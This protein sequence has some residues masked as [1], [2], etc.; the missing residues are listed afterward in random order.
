MRLSHIAAPILALALSAGALPAQEA[1]DAVPDSRVV[2]ALDLDYPGSDIATLLDSSLDACQAACLN[3]SQCV[4][5]T[6]NQRSGSC[7][8]KFDIGAPVPF[9]GAISA[10]IVPTDPAVLM[11]EAQRTADLS[12]LE[13]WELVSASGLAQTIGRAHASNDVPASDLVAAA[14]AAGATIEGFRLLGAA[15]AVTDSPLLWLDY[16]R[17]G[18]TVVSPVSSE[19]STARSRVIPALANAYLRSGDPVLS[20][21]ILVEL[22]SVLQGQSRGPDSVAPLRLALDLAPSRATEELLDRAVGL[23]GF[24]VAE[25]QVDSDGA[26]PRLCVLFTEP[27]VQAGV[28]YAP[29]VQLPD[30]PFTTEVS[31]NQ[32]CLDGVEH[33]QR[34]RLVIR[35]GLPA[36]SGETTARAA[37]LTLY[38]RDRAPQVRFTTRAYVLPRT[39]EAALPVQ[40]VNLTDLDLTL[41]RLGDRNVLRAMDNGVF[42]QNLYEWDRD[43]I[44]GQMG[45]TVWEGSLT[46]GTDLNR[47]VT[48]RIPLAEALAGQEPGLYALTAAIPGS[49]PW[50]QPAATQWF[51]L[52]DLGLAT[53]AGNDGLTVA[54]RGLGDAAARPGV[55][56]Q[57]L[58][59]ANEVLG[60]ASTDADGI[61]RFDAGL[62]RG[63]GSAEPAL[64]LARSDDDIAFLSLTDPAFDLSDRG[65]E[66]RDPAP[67]IDVFL[68]TDRGAYR[69]GEVIYTTALM[70]DD[71]ADAVLGLPLT[72]ILTRPDGVEY[73][74]MASLADAAGGHVFALPVAGNA[75][76]GTW[77]I[78]VRSDL[79][80]EPLA[81]AAVLVEDF[82]PERIDFDLTAPE[83]VT[84]GDTP[85]L[86]LAAQYLFGAPAADLPIEGE[87]TLRAA[88]SVDGFPGYVFGQYD[89]PFDT[90]VEYF[91]GDLTGPDGAATVLLPLPF[92][93]GGVGQPLTAT[94]VVRL[95]EGSGRPVERRVE[96]PVRPDQP[97]I[98]IRP[99]FDGVAPEGGTAGF[100][101]IGLAPDLTP[102]PMEVTWTINRVETWYQWFNL[103]GD[104]Q[105]EPSTNRTR[106]ASGTV[107]LGDGPV[108]VSAPVEWGEYEIVVERTGADYAVASTD[109][110]AG[111]YAP[112][113]AT[114]TP[115]LLEASLDRPEYR[116]GDTAVFRIVPRA[117]GVAV[118]SVMAD[119]LISLQTVEVTE[120][121]NLIELPVTDDWGTGVYVSASVIRPMDVAAGRNPSRALGLSHAFV[122]P[123]SRALSVVLETP[124]DPQPRAPLTVGIDVQGTLPGEPVYVTLAAV[125]VGILNLTG[126]DSP[127]PQGHYFGQRELG[128]ELRDIY[129]QLI[130]G[131]TGA[132]GEVRS[133]GDAMGLMGVQA[134]PP[135]EELLAFF[136]GPVA[137]DENGR[138]EVTFDLPAFN[139]TVRLMAVAWSPRGVGQA[140]TDITVRDPVVVAASLPRFLSPGDESRL[141]LEI[142]NTDAGTGEMQLAV[143]GSRG[144]FIDERQAFSLAP[145]ARVVFDMAVNA[146]EPGDHRIDVALTLADGRVLTRTLSLPV[147][148]LDPEVAR[149]SRFT[150]DP[151]QTFRF[152]NAVFADLVPGGSSAT[153]SVGPLARFDAAGLLATLDRYPYGCTEQVT[154]QAMPLLYFADVS[155]AMGLADPEQIEERIAQ[156]I[157]AVLANQDANGSFGLWRP[158]S[159]DLWLDAYVTDFLSRA[160]ARGH[161]V[162]DLAFRSAI[163]NLRNRVNYYPDFESG[164]RDLAYA[165]LVLAREGAAAVGDL[166]Y[167]ADERATAFDTPLAAAQIGAALAQYGDQPRADAMFAQAQA[168]IRGLDRAEPL[169]WR[170]DY[171]TDRRDVAAVLA[172]AVEA[173]ST[174]VDR[175]LLSSRLARV[176]DAVS[177]QEAVWTLMAA[178]ALIDDL[179]A[180]DITFDGAAPD[181]PLVRYAED[182]VALTPVAVQNGGTSPVDVTVTTFGVP[183]DPEPAGGNGYGIQRQHFTLDGQEIALT[184]VPAGTRIVTV[185]TVQ[186]FGF[187]SGRL[188]VA[189]PL[190]AGFE[191]DNPN[192]LRAGDISALPWLEV[193]DARS[194]QFRSDRFLAAVD[195]SGDR[196]FRLAY[197][198]RA[199]SPG[200]F[201]HAA[202][203]VE[204][205]YRPQMRARTATGEASVTP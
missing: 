74:R 130:D 137:V 180:T 205:M 91:G 200:S 125:D 81:T 167:F 21:E 7:F 143:T 98:G 85:D 72:A 109:F 132:M 47:D 168:L 160:R 149:V 101:L 190:P 5:F 93:E 11:A 33:G 25:T 83:V 162:P 126:F 154:S 78:E 163:D 22:A 48:T 19:T 36:A 108:E 82:L 30:V 44:E 120:G 156:S 117:A 152:D 141:R 153:L 184:D 188:M 178:N 127:D 123:E 140:D 131:M 58:S 172:L 173:G 15:V 59:R 92:V 170:A 29:F 49:D 176:G 115:D 68:T 32:L 110:Y 122:N 60:T 144:V 77:R 63:T 87:V 161:A 164:G 119:R 157:T 105:W 100:A 151:G 13:P 128:V 28:D 4:A 84:H 135:T 26:V 139:G 193:V 89:A 103:Y 142:T 9:A 52:T 34:Y 66:G 204:D 192:L 70:R 51:I 80:A 106:I 171:G 10:R 138:A 181:G 46:V 61:A 107:T 17:L 196:V 96:F 148:T 177:T 56:V 39:G 158:E 202:A 75:P 23:W 1:P 183:I 42:A 40:T 166:R 62:M 65:V 43:W 133:G 114:Q 18:R 150:L 155:A 191:I 175:D 136:Q 116:I 97:M 53:W 182:D 203:S 111:W 102:A 2:T 20:S 79:E 174:A 71:R 86:S 189:D 37:E 197:I 195:W 186:P 14:D 134:P 57:L 16:G 95:T 179:R 187:Q 27:L 35:A 3:D 159:G 147:R 8:P 31:D 73:S 67:P 38:V 185:L 198:A 90:R 146:T 199:V 129:G 55:E 24:R 50:D 99:L 201:H 45:Q 104:W 6:Y 113:G 165:L 88:A 194:A 112:A 54:L 69:P 94:A 12:F 64:V 41:Q 169:I 124:L 121:E 145:G 118:V 76:T